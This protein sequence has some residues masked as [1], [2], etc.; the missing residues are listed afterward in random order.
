MNVIKVKRVKD[1]RA[2]ICET[3]G[4]E[5]SENPYWSLSKSIGLHK[6]G[7]KDAKVTMYGMVD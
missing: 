5:I 4:T 6:T 7:C 1:A 3:C 2:A